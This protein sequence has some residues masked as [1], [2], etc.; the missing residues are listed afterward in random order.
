MIIIIIINEALPGKVVL[1][2]RV[3][4]AYA[5]K[6]MKMLLTF[7]T[8]IYGEAELLVDGWKDVHCFLCIQVVASR[9]DN[10]WRFYLCHPRCQWTLT[11]QMY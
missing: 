10:G 11:R 1:G 5:Q 4:L 8:R 3:S 7:G 2:A 9:S 6:P